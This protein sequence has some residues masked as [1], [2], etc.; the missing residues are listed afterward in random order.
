MFKTWQKYDKAPFR[1]QACG[2]TLKTGAEIAYSGDIICRISAYLVIWIEEVGLCFLFKLLILPFFFEKIGVMTCTM[3]LK[4]PSFLLGKYQLTGTV[5]FSV[6]FA[7]VFLNIY[8]PFSDTA[9]F[10]LGDS[11]TFLFTLLF[12]VASVLILIASRTIMYRSKKFFEISYPMYVLWCILEIVLI[13]SLYTVMTLDVSTLNIPAINV[14][15]KS[16]MY[17]C[18][19][20]GFPYILS[21]MYFAIIDKNNTIKLMNYNNVVTDIIPKSESSNQKI[22]LFDNSGTLKLSISLENL[23]YIES[24]DNYVRVWY[25]DSNGELHQYMVRCR[26]KTIEDSFKGSR[27]VRC[28][29][30]YIVN[31][32]KVGA[33]RKESVGYYLYMKIAEIPAIPITKSYEPEILQYF[34]ET[35]VDAQ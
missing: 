30:K 18:I 21:G 3:N 4:L 8:I 17:G 27:L 29:R 15:G 10:A 25:S 20:L 11:V 12:I 16:F 5:T 7:I 2:E 9:W 32:D 1:R 26:L 6:L 33:L 13:C 34:T 35:Q 23:F 24:S 22:N 19:A 31:L 28:N 14:F